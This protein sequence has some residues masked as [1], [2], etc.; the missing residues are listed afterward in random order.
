[1]FWSLFKVIIISMHFQWNSYHEERTKI[2][3]EGLL[4]P[5]VVILEA[6]AEMEATRT[7]KIVYLFQ[8]PSNHWFPKQNYIHLIHFHSCFPF[9]F[10]LDTTS[11]PTESLEQIAAFHIEKLLSR[12]S[13]LSENLLLQLRQ[14]LTKEWGTGSVGTLPKDSIQKLLTWV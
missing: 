4:N 11:K 9:S 5:S 13:A 2:I 12:S 8:I 3:Q 10:I 7:G 14:S 1:M 6:M